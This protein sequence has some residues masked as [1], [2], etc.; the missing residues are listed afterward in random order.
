MLAVLTRYGYAYIYI[1]Y[2]V[3]KGAT[4]SVNV[5]FLNILQPELWNFL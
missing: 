1:L 3:G 4:L 2:F 5:P